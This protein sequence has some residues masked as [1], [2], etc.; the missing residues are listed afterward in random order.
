M[1]CNQIRE[2][3]PELAAGMEAATPEVQEHIA[4]CDDCAAHLRDL[5]KTMALLDEW[6]A[7]EPSAVFRHPP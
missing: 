1:D 4:S 3:L 2:R 6:Q 5:Q 7:P